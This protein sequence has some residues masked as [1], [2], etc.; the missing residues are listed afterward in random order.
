MDPR[1]VWTEV[2]ISLS[3]YNFLADRRSSFPGQVI[4]SR[5]FRRARDHLG[6]TVLVVGSFSSGTDIARLLGSLNLNPGPSTRVY[7]SSS[8]LPNSS[9][10]DDPDEPWKPYIRQVPLIDHL[11][12]P[13]STHPKGRIHFTPGPEPTETIDDVDTIIFATGY[14][15]SL[16]FCKT[17]DSPWDALSLLDEMITPEQ[18]QGGHEWEIG[19][20]RGL[21]MDHMDEMLLFLKGD[22]TIAFPGLRES[23]TS[24]FRSAL[25]V[26]RVRSISDCS[27]PIRRGPSSARC[28]SLGRTP[29]FPSRSPIPASEPKQP[30]G[31]P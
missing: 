9:K 24:T 7:Q 26:L 3:G 1:N 6:Q 11:E 18:R 27:V 28:L 30:S 29:S 20:Q 21:K 23:N 22:R 16:P 19:G 15:N 10:T 31:L 12:P 13:S 5:E 25:R 2:S 17:A 8:G 14:Y 4:H